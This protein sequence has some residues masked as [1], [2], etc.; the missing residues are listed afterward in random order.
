MREGRQMR[1]LFLIVSER[2]SAVEWSG[3]F[4]LET[5]ILKR[6][7]NAWA[8]DSGTYENCQHWPRLPAW[9]WTNHLSCV[10]STRDWPIFSVA[11]SAARG[12]S[13][14]TGNLRT[15]AARMNNRAKARHRRTRR[16]G[17]KWQ[18]WF[19]A[20]R[21]FSSLARSAK[22][23][24]WPE[25]ARRHYDCCGGLLF[26]QSAR[27]MICR[28]KY[29]CVQLALS[30]FP[31]RFQWGSIGVSTGRRQLSPRCPRGTAATMFLG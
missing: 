29:S 6:R 31:F 28:Q 21:R 23:A 27:R 5:A 17:K 14:I 10:P 15:T 9:T 25:D 8:A 16:S 18:S 20:I 4:R 30:Y 22:P 12:S 19:P 3:I 13:A 7:T 11:K 1:S 26:P 24:V 2:R